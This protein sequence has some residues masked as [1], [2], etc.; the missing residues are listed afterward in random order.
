MPWNWFKDNNE[1]ASPSKLFARG[2]EFIA[3]GLFNGVD[4][5]VSKPDYNTIFDR[6]S[7]ALEGTKDTIKGVINSIIEFV[8][9]MA[10]GVINGIN[11]VIGALNRLHVDVPG[12]VT[13]LTGISEFGF[14]IPLLSTI[15]IPRLA[16]GGFPEQG[17]MFIAREAGAE[18]VGNIGR[19]TAVV[20]NDQIVASI[21]GGVAEANE[22]QNAL[23]REQNSLLRAIL[24][25]DSGVRLDGKLLTDSVEKYQRE[26]GRVLITGG[27]V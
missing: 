14:N 8:E 2:G 25:K 22:E 5:G 6:I 16:E 26:R 1:I 7:D 20:N 12:W 18:M 11:K 13:D 9:G 19:R 3:E 27:V 21:S 23:L 4:G 17:Q 15:S 10:N 24:E